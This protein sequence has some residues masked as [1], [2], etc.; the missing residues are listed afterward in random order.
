MSKESQKPKMDGIESITYIPAAR[1]LEVN[2]KSGI[3]FRHLFV[4]L[5]ILKQYISSFQNNG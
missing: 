1:I 3:R 2:Y 4:S 5:K